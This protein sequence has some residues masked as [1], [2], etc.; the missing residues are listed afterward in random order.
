MTWTFQ[1]IG[2]RSSCAGLRRLLHIHAGSLFVVTRERSV[3]SD[4]I[5][6]GGY[7]SIEATA[8]SPWYPLLRTCGAADFLDPT[9]EPVQHPSGQFR[10]IRRTL[11][12]H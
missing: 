11:L 2:K 3:V 12:L 5:F 4:M 1:V 8:S 7:H 6:V 9:L 10:V